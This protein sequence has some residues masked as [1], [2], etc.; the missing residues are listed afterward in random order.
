M[1]K[2]YFLRA[3]SLVLIL[4]ILSA[5][6]K[7]DDSSSAIQDISSSAV[8]SSSSQQSSSAGYV[9]APVTG[10][11]TSQASSSAE[12][13]SAS[14]AQIS[15][16]PSLDASEMPKAFVTLIPIG[17]KL[18]QLLEINMPSNW[19]FDGCTLFD[20]DGVKKCEVLSLRRAAKDN[21]F[22]TELMLKYNAEMAKDGENGLIAKQEQD[23]NGNKCKFYI[24]KAMPQD[25]EK[26]FNIYF[27][28]MN[29]GDYTAELA[30]YSDDT[31]S[32]EIPAEVTAVLNTI[33]L[34]DLDK[35]ASDINT[36]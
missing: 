16:E 10:S 34:V 30:F 13:A 18:T 9:S 35:P 28:L 4:P 15:S 11:N 12:A 14:T 6:G 24:Y 23:Y 36:K 32:A 27:C 7:K 20:V 25:A 31:S 29:L 5:C 17:E 26:V 21:P 8:S 22:T 2:H 1:N 19:H 33:A 3:M